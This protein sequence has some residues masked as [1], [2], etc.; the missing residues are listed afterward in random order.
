MIKDKAIDTNIYY[1]I[2]SK[3]YI[4]FYNS[5]K[6]PF[7]IV[8]ECPVL[9]QK[10]RINTGTEH[11]YTFGYANINAAAQNIINDKVND[12]R[13]AAYYQKPKYTYI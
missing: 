7:I 1:H 9:I 10:I 4:V 8:Y 12:C 5:K 2:N 13:A 3:S 6:R 11:R